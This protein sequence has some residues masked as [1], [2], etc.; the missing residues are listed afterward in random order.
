[1]TVWVQVH[2]AG[3]LNADEGVC[4]EVAWRAAFTLLGSRQRTQLLLW[5]GNTF[6][7]GLVF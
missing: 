1:M 2:T 4:M 6:A 5:F 7:R 3:V